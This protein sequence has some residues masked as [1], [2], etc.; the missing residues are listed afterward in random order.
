MHVVR[1]VD[2]IQFKEERIVF[3]LV[4]KE[5]IMKGRVA[6]MASVVAVLLTIAPCATAMASD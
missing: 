3:V 6:F 2:A 4:I 5:K 1:R